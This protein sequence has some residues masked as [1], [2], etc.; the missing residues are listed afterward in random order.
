MSFSGTRGQGNKM[1]KN[2]KYILYKDFILQ[3]FSSFVTPFC[4]S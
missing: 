3:F 1:F 4:D 2:T